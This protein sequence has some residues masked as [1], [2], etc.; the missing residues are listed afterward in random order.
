[1]QLAAKTVER[2]RLIRRSLFNQSAI[3]KWV[4]HFQALRYLFSPYF[5][6]LNQ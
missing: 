5:Q 2:N 3:T 1:M 4:R 6:N